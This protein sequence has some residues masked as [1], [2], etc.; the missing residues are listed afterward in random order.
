MKEGKNIMVVRFFDQPYLLYV[1]NVGK[2]ILEKPNGFHVVRKAHYEK[3][4][5][6]LIIL[7]GH[8]KIT[9]TRR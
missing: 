9:F 4:L 3:S 7:G 8:K 6:P 5:R 2:K 1:S